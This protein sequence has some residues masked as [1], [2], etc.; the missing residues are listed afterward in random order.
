[1][2][3]GESIK[4]LFEGCNRMAREVKCQVCQQKTPMDQMEKIQKGSTNKYYHSE[5][6]QKHLKHQAFIDKELKESDELWEVIKDIHG[7]VMMPSDFYAKWIQR[8]RN[9]TITEKGRLVKKYRQGVPYVVMKDAYLLCRKDIKYHKTTKNFE[10]DMQELIYCFKVVLSK[11]NDAYARQARKAKQETINNR[12]DN[13]V[14]DG[15]EQPEV[16]ANNKDDD[17]DIS[18]LLN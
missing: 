14:Q 4:Y 11:I 16:E 8:L 17:M 3:F 7:I 13:L 5:C 2:C 9:G 6:L 10:S 18:D 1:M 15:L 12:V